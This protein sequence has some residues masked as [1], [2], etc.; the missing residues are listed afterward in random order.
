[1]IPRAG[2]PVILAVCDDPG[3]MRRIE[4][5]L[6]TRYDADYHVVLRD[7][8]GAGL[9]AL[10]HLEEAEEEL[11]LV[12][13]DQHLRG[14]D[15]VGFLTRVGEGH[16]TAKRLL[17][18]TR[19]ERSGGAVLPQAIALGRIDFFEPKPG[20]PPNETFHEIVTGLLEEWSRPRRSRTQPSVH[21]VGER[22]SPRTH[23]L[24][25]LFGRYLIPCAFLPV[26]SD[27]GGE[28]LR[29]TG[30]AAQSLPVLVMPDGTV[31]VDPTNEEAADAY[32]GAEALPANGASI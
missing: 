19:T 13:A 27:E 3:D 20:P 21:L 30:Q 28:L 11:A 1:M 18:T 17:L 24:R 8:A 10:E 23:E 32:A 25:D 4:R 7:S 14:T 22:W 2:R 5:E 16:P 31:L 12:L 29:E 26:D 15:G 6:L 9:E